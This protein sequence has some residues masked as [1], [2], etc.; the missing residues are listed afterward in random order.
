MGRAMTFRQVC[1]GGALQEA[2]S[3]QTQP[4]ILLVLIPKLLMY[5]HRNDKW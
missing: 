4:Q 3:R 2:A 5:S 1:V